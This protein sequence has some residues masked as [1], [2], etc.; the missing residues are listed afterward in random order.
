MIRVYYTLFLFPT[1]IPSLL[2]YLCWHAWGGLKQGSDQRQRRVWRTECTI[3]H[4]TKKKIRTGHTP[5]VSEVWISIPRGR[6]TYTSIQSTT[7]S[8][9]ETHGDSLPIISLWPPWP[10]NTGLHKEWHTSC[11]SP[12]SGIKLEHDNME[13]PSWRSLANTR[14]RCVREGPFSQ[15]FRCR[16]LS[17]WVTERCPLGMEWGWEG[18][19]HW[20]Q[21]L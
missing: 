14:Q 18:S 10:D 12:A 5:H 16:S 3:Y 8:L 11:H 20:T 17:T 9:R 6:T 21:L 2:P 15:T 13:Q 7:H 1:P 4:F 19:A